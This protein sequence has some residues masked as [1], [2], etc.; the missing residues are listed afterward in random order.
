MSASR[1]PPRAAAKKASTAASCGG[2]QRTNRSSRIYATAL[3]YALVAHANTNTVTG[4]MTAN[5]RP[6][7]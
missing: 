5:A 4:A 7:S 6:T 3:W 1:S 2:R